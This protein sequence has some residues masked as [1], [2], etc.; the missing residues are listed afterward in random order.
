MNLRNDDC[1]IDDTF[2]FI[3]F[4]LYRVEKKMKIIKKGKPPKEQ[5]IRKTCD[6]CKIIF[7][8]SK[9]ET[10]RH[11]D[12]RNGSFRSIICPVCSEKKYIDSFSEGD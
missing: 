7:E 8:F 5:I 6:N 12:Y 3:N 1:N 9:E 10:E 11:S 4:N 2:D